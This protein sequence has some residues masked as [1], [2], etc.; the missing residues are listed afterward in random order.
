MK[1]PIDHLGNLANALTISYAI[2]RH[3][4][5]DIKV[6][7]RRGL[8]YS[9]LTI[10]VTSGYLLILFGVQSL[11]HRTGYSDLALAAAVALVMAALSTPLRNLT[12]ER[13]D[14]LLFRDSYEYRRMLSSFRS[15]VSN[16]MNLERLAHDI[17]NP[18]AHTLRAEWAALLLPDVDSGDFR[19]RFVSQSGTPQASL[20]LRLRRESPLLS[21]LARES[22]VIPWELLDTYPEGLASRNPSGTAWEPGV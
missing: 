3:Q 17:L 15:N 18:L 12:Q 14:R 16:A 7:I 19:A 2:L 13:V 5:L 11:F 4:L 6:V 10:G 20:Q 21:L 22:Q 9:V 8:A 1:Y